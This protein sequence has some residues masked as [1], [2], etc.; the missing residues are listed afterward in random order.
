MKTNSD[1]DIITDIYVVLTGIENVDHNIFI[2]IGRHKFNW[3]MRIINVTF[4][5]WY[6]KAALGGKVTTQVKQ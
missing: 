1:R 6:L 2:L 5:K 4:L 3:Y